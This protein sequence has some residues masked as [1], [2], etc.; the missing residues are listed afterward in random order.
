M[1]HKQVD[2]QSTPFHATTGE[3]AQVHHRAVS[4]RRR[5]PLA[6][7]EALRNDEPH[8]VCREHDFQPSGAV[9]R[10][11]RVRHASKPERG[12]RLVTQNGSR[13]I[14]IGVETPPDALAT[15]V[16]RQQR[17]QQVLARAVC[18]H[19]AQQQEMPRDAG[20]GAEP[21]RGLLVPV[22]RLPDGVEGEV[23]LV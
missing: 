7:E 11:A 8:D 20:G 21:L 16:R 23:V 3:V 5:S 12:E 13:P 10:G 22:A 1:K 18:R 15:H 4:H 2:T 9:R 19:A 17:L 6:R 14:G